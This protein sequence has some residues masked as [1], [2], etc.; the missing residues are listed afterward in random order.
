MLPYGERASRAVASIATRAAA[1]G[2]MELVVA[3]VA[4]ALA[5]RRA[6]PVPDVV[7]VAK[8]GAAVAWFE[9]GRPF[10]VHPTLD[11]LLAMHGVACVARAIA[12]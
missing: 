9:D 11:D 1:L 5:S 10:V 3:L 6:L 12:A 7:L 4:V 2:G 8:D